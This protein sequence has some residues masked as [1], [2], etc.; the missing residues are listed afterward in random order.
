LW[1]STGPG[2][3]AGGATVAGAGRGDGKKVCVTL[4]GGCVGRLGAFIS[5]PWLAEARTREGGLKSK[6]A[7][8]QVA[9]MA[10]RQTR[11]RSAAGYITPLSSA[12]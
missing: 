8:T 1:S 2:L 12:G 3:A 9:V 4:G 6:R 10:L 7:I 11:L 5:S